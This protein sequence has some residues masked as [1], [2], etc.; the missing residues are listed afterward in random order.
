VFCGLQFHRTDAN[1]D[2]PNSVNASIATTCTEPQQCTIANSPRSVTGGSSV[3]QPLTAQDKDEVSPRLRARGDVI[4]L[5]TDG[6]PVVV[7]SLQTA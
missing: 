2:A 1:R 4:Q 3:L 6:I 5:V 7:D